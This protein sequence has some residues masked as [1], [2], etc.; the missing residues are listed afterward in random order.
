MDMPLDDFA[1]MVFQRTARNDLH[2]FSLTGRMLG[3]F[4]EF[5]GQQNLSEIAGRTGLELRVLKDVARKLLKLNLIE[6][7]AKAV[8]AVD[9]DFFSYL[10]VQLALAVGPLAPVLIEDALED[11][12]YSFSDFP[13][14][15][16]AELVDLLS[17]EIQREG[18]RSNFRQKMLSKIK[19]N[20][21]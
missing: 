13:A 4:A 17:Q 18:K 21:Y 6:P 10:N 2:E 14:H 11:L 19:E 7:T 5:D 8:S 12:G 15:H 16:A 20:G 1:F 3:I 9:H